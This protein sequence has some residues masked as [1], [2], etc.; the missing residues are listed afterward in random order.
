MRAVIHAY[1]RALLAQ[2]HRRMLMLSLVPFLLAGLLWA[3][4][5]WSGLQPLIDAVRAQFL[6]HDGFRASADWLAALGLGVLTSVIVPLT[7]MLLLLPLM[8]MTALV[9]IG[10]AAMPALV[11]HVGA[12][13]F[14]R[15]EKKR[16]GSLAGG[17]KA[18]AGALLAFVPLWL[19]TLPLYAL[20]PLGLAAHAL[21]WGWLTCRV[22]AYDALAEHASGAER[23]ELMRRHRWPLLAIGVVSGAAGALPGWLFLGGSA[24]AVVL[25]PFL[26]AGAIWLYVL[27]FMF[28]G[29]WFAYYCL[30]ALNNLRRGAGAAPPLDA[31]APAIPPAILRI[32]KGQL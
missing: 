2:L 14:A 31:A 22:V 28:T 8:I 27:I 20:A 21:L 30:E 11:R 18:A 7:A 19:L 9:F 6:L 16:G 3:L 25:F 24:A 15:L 23:R 5:L 10:L 1:G 4:L 26:A 29:L 12:R 13:D 32:E 17:V